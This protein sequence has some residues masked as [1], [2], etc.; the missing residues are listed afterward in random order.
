[1]LLGEK[2]RK[3]RIARKLS[4]EQLADELRVSRQAISKWE[5]GESIP[6]T[7]NLISLSKFYGVSFDYLLLDE[8]NVSNELEIKRQ[9]HSSVFVLGISGLI[10]GLIVSF[11]LWITYQSMLMVSLG[12]II[13]IVSVTLVLVKQSELPTKLQRLF[14]MIST[15]TTLPF[16]CF[17]VGSLTMKLYPKPY[18]VVLEFI[19]E[20]MIYLLVCT[21]ITIGIKKMR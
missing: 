5:L 18:L 13:Q 9:P 20:F 4:Q 16:I 21:V 1:M 17:Y 6:D 14:L 7:E 19:V 2:L 15:W 10:I 12:L 3:L 11:I 8:L